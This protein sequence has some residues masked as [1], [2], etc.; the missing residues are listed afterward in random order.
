M[1]NILIY[2]IDE[3]CTGKYTTRKI[4]TKPHP[5]LE[6]RIFH[7][8]VGEDIDIVLHFFKAVCSNIIR[9]SLC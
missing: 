4:P 3:C 9:L 7:T 5:G 1:Y 6:W 2:Y 8:L